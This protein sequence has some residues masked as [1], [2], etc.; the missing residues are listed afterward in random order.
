MTAECVSLQYRPCTVKAN[1]NETK[2]TAAFNDL[3]HNA[4]QESHSLLHDSLEKRLSSD[5]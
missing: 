3:P 1:T 4:K 2:I 5:C